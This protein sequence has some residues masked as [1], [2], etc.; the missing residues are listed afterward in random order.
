LI[1]EVGENFFLKPTTSK[2]FTIYEITRCMEIMP[3]LSVCV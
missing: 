1:G 2:I 3:Y